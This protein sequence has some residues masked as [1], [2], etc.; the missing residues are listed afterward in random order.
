MRRSMTL[1]LALWVALATATSMVIDVAMSQWQAPYALRDMWGWRDFLI[2][3]AGNVP[4]II[5]PT[6]LALMLWVRVV[7]SR[8]VLKV[9]RGYHALSLVAVG[10]L[11]MLLTVTIVLVMMSMV[12]DSSGVLYENARLSFAATWETDGWLQWTATVALIIA[13]P[14]LVLAPRLRRMGLV[15]FPSLEKRQIA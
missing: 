2:G 14:R 7:Q 6:M 5:A 10:V 12:S 8:S 13:I 11:S 4:F 3:W 15:A 9:S 1:L